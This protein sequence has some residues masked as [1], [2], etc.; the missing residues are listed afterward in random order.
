MKRDDTVKV[1]EPTKNEQEGNYMFTKFDPE[2]TPTAPACLDLRPHDSGVDLV[3]V[4]NKGS[5]EPG[6]TVLTM[7]NDGHVILKHSHKWHPS[8][9]KDGKGYTAVRWEERN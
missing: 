2:F 9:A 7:H 1:K 4:D 8:L 3:L 6:G 5:R